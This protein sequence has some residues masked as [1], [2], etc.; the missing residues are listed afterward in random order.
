MIGA[1][2]AFD[3]AAG[4]A[5]VSVLTYR[6]IAS[7]SP[8]S[9]ACWPASSCGGRD[10][11]LGEL[12]PGADPWLDAPAAAPATAPDSL[13]RCRSSPSSDRTL[14][15]GSRSRPGE[16]RATTCTC[17]RAGRACGWR[18][19]RPSSARTP[20]CARSPA[21]SRARPAAAAGG[22]GRRAAAGGDARRQRLLTS[23][24]GAAATRELLAVAP[25]AGPSRHELDE[26]FSA[27]CAAAL[28]AR[29]SPSAT[30]VPGDVLPLE[31]YGNLVADARANGV[32]VLVDLSS[33]R[34]DARSEG[35]P[36]VVKINDW[37]LA[38]YVAGPSTGSR[39]RAAA[40]RLVERGAGAV[41]DHTGRRAGLRGRRRS[42]VG[43][44]AA[45]ARARLPRGLRRL[46][47][48]RHGRRAGRGG[49]LSAALGS[50]RRQGRPTSCATG[51]AA[52][53][54]PVIEELAERVELRE[55]RRGSEGRHDRSPRRI[56]RRAPRGRSSRDGRRRGGPHEALPVPPRADGPAGA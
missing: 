7:G 29:C 1:L 22:P 50:A 12:P 43:A 37:E 38:E 11:G 55:L 35:G 47:D 45:A 23:S 14:S 40:E 25:G 5:V 24:T 31:V 27:T 3:V 36:D 26:L 41:V 44:R 15:S 10:Q 18:G 30:P 42:S 33:P 48:G 9:P 56:A 4:L 53:A 52:P 21:A 8:R 16:A 34:L 51:W 20:C 46:D 19:W 17:T 28:E 32:P 2:I 39:L 49:E 54:A 6:A 13:A